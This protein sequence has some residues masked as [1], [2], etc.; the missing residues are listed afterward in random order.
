MKGRCRTVILIL[1]GL[2]A[3]AC[4][5]AALLRPREPVY[6]G[7]ALSD[8]LEEVNRAGSLNKTGPASNAIRAM[9][10]NALPFLLA[11]IEHEEPALKIHLAKLAQKQSLIKLGFLEPD[12]LRCP[13]VWALKELG[14]EASPLI[15]DLIKLL[16][17][18]AGS[19]RSARSWWGG[20]GLWAIGAESRPALE[21]ACGSSNER[22][23]ATAASLLA[24]VSV[25]VDAWSWGWGKSPVSVR[26][27]FRL[28]SV[29]V[30]EEVLEAL[31]RGLQNKD[32]AI[33][34]AS[35][36][37]LKQLRSLGNNDQAALVVVAL[38]DALKDEE[39]AVREAAANAL[40]KIYPQAA[41]EAG[42]K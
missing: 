7:K 10:T 22:V 15:P 9:G 13:S 35:A 24:W 29:W 23:R 6:Q 34:H 42:L 2:V 36:D 28:G 3:A 1:S 12:P 11:H 31:R 4:L 20:M 33:R 5:L 25:R 41:T 37:A 18:D 30:T 19:T 26:P 16:E 40:K 32:A 14:A 21:R 17:D 8:W 27:R 39:P 38:R